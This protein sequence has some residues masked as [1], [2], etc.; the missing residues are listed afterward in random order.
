MVFG[1]VTVVRA[2]GNA[3]EA[4]AD[5]MTHLIAVPTPGAIEEI[6]VTGGV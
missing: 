1:A 5:D 6:S 3:C 2:T 4:A